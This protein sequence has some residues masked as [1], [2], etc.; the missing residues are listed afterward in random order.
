M[1]NFTDTD[2]L[3]DYRMLE[4][5]ARFVHAV[6]RDEKKKFTRIDK[7]LPVVSQKFYQLNIHILYICIISF[8]QVNNSNIKIV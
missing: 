6:K 8:C 2:L 3:S 4:E 1:K 5:C 7:D